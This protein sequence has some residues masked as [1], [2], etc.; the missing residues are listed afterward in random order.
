[1]HYI[2]LEL[3]KIGVVCSSCFFF[4]PSS[5]MRSHDLWVWPRESCDLIGHAHRSHDRSCGTPTTVPPSSHRVV[6]VPE[7]PYLL[8][9]IIR[10][11]IKILNLLPLSKVTKTT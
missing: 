8:S 10:I 11:C 9:I 4:A 1:M 7:T 2:T 5:G 3:I 6:I